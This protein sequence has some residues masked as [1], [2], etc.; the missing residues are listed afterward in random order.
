MAENKKYLDY[1]GLTEFWSLVKNYYSD[2][3]SKAASAIQGVYVLNREERNELNKYNLII[4]FYI[5]HKK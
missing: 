3:V 1:A 5:Y 2:T 4:L